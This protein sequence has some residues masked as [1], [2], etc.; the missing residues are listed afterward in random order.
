MVVTAFT[1]FVGE[2][3]TDWDEAFANRHLAEDKSL[4]KADLPV[5][6]QSDQREGR[7]PQKLR[8]L[9][10]EAT[11]SKSG[12]QGWVYGYG[13]QITCTEATFPKMV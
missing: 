10:T 8:H 11:R 1:A 4:F 5:W 3:V 9:D 12:Y 6:H 7:I 2:E 13:I